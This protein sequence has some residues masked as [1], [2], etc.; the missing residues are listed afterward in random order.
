ME[1][2]RWRGRKGEPA[3]EAH[4]LPGPEQ[5]LFAGLQALAQEARGPET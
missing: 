2:P 3:A 1:G 5:P 4:E